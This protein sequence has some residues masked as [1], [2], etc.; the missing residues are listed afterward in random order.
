M[1]K[2]R[3]IY[4]QKKASSVAVF[5]LRVVIS[6]LIIGSLYAIIE[7][8]LNL[9]SKDDVETTT[10]STETQDLNPTT[11]SPIVETGIDYLTEG[12]DLELPVNGAS[13]YASVALRLREGP[14]IETNE[15]TTL[16][17]GSGFTILDEKDDWWQIETDN[18]IGWVMHKYCFINL[19]D[20]IPSIV[21]YNSNAD[22]SKIMTSKKEV[23]N[24]TGQ[25]L[26]DALVFNNRIDKEVYITPV[27]Y[28]MASKISAAQQAA[29]ADGNTLIIYE[30]FRPYAVQEKIFNNVS[31]LVATDSIVKSG[32]SDL[33]WSIEWF[34]ASG[35]SNH[36][37]GYAID[38]TLGKV[39]NKETKKT[40]DYSFTNILEYTEYSMPTQILELS[41]ASI[42]FKSP[43]PPSSN[44]LWKE[45]I[46]VDS[47][48]PEAIWLQKY[49]TEA[50]LTPLA[51]EWWHFNELEAAANVSEIQSDGNYFIQKGYSIAPNDNIEAP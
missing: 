38:V 25:K 9:K 36:Q 14:S 51:S 41:I 26:Y 39:L 6:L 33:Q 30:G 32:I 18:N 40:G 43:V 48:T 34:I 23:P 20:V 15:I 44:T 46:L 5:L 19:P 17:A 7:P 42:V 13:G 4:E 37:M 47:I 12:G 50:G 45:A 27:L 10:L 16:M 2:K 29:L 8:I 3:M 24:I 31:A 49:C 28:A 35:V 1:R 21:Y 11:E 22:A